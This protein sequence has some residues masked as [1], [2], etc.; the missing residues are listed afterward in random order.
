MNTTGLMLVAALQAGALIGVSV[1]SLVLFAKLRVQL[2][3]SN[4]RA[5]TAEVELNTRGIRIAN[6]YEELDRVKA[7]RD[8]ARGEL[9]VARAGCGIS[10]IT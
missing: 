3:L 7:E 1:Y 2:V 6:L 10:A 8:S 9:E 4:R 5:H